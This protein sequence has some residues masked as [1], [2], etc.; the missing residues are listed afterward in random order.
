MFV[1]YVRRRRRGDLYIET[2]RGRDETRDEVDGRTYAPRV[3]FLQ[4]ELSL[5]K[6]CGRDGEIWVI[7]QGTHIHCDGLSL[8]AQFSTCSTCEMQNRDRRKRTHI[9]IPNPEAREIAARTF[10]FR[11]SV[12]SQHET[13][14]KPHD[15][16]MRI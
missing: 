11:W 8:S 14:S 13:T 5:E 9:N 12:I 16:P 10:T 7:F 15:C 3:S 1:E 2:H 4:L 6:Y